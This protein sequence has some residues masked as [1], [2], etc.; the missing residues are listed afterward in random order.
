MFDFDDD[1][2]QSASQVLL[3]W[4][5]GT[6]CDTRGPRWHFVL[7]ELTASLHVVSPLN[8]DRGADDA[9]TSRKTRKHVLTHR[10]RNVAGDFDDFFS[11]KRTSSY[12]VIVIASTVSGNCATLVP[13]NLLLQPLL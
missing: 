9:H 13:I 11:F 12:R 5:A 4:R 1:R 10:W 6:D 2:Q 8:G 3:R 7:S